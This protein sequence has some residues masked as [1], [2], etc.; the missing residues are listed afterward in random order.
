MSHSDQALSVVQQA[1]RCLEAGD[2]SGLMALM[3]TNLDYIEP[4][5]PGRIPWAGHFKGLEGFAQWMA[6]NQE[7][8]ENSRIEPED[9]V[10][11]GR[12]VVMFARMSATVRKTGKPLE[13]HLAIAFTVERGRL[14]TVRIYQDTA[15]LLEAIA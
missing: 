3:D 15:A 12:R 5:P 4:G 14:R 1:Y 13:S 9:Y 2:I 7:H 6:S 8:L 11:D 10:S